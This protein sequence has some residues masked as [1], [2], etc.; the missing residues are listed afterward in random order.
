M[1]DL[2]YIDK[3]TVGKDSLRAEVVVAEGMPLMTSEDIEATARVYY[4]APGIA[5]HM[6]LGDKGEKFRDCMGDTELA[7]LLEH[8]TVEI[9]NQTGLAG[10]IAYGRTQ[11]TDEEGVYEIELSCPDDVLTVGALSSAVFM[12]TW[13]YVNPQTQA[14]DFNGTVQGLKQLVLS[15]RP[16]DTATPVS[17]SAQD[18]PAFDDDDEAAGPID[19]EGAVATPR[20]DAAAAQFGGAAGSDYSAVAD[21]DD[22]TDPGATVPMTPLA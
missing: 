17:G 16:A 14:P 7:H 13:A 1:A 21:D 15:L 3:V 4:L 2:F 20:A 12:M 18:A 8:L 10:K 6:C 5:E 19:T 11:A 22:V 9:M